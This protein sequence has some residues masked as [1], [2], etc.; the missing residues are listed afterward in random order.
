M[1][2]MA[3]TVTTTLI[4]VRLSLAVSVVMVSKKVRGSSSAES[5]NDSIQLGWSRFDS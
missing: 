3:R 4:G 2:L 1:A 5:Y